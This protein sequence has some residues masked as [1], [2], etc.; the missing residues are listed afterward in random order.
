MHT[1]RVS[2]STMDRVVHDSARNVEE[3]WIHL[4]LPGQVAE[5]LDIWSNAVSTGALELVKEHHAER[6]LLEQHARLPRRWDDWE[7]PIVKDLA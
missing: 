7:W 2:E 5:P 6:K 4:Q 1:E 3:A